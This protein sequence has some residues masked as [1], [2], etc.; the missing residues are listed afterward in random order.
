MVGDGD[1]HGLVLGIGSGCW[2]GMGEGGWDRRLVMSVMEGARLGEGR[3]DDRR[4]AVF[5]RCTIRNKWP[6]E[7]I[8]NGH[9][10]FQT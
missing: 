1:R 5:V 4:S 2:R 6:P 10:K 9:K 7:T 3:Y 8:T